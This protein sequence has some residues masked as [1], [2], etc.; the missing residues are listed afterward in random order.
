MSIYKSLLTFLTLF[1]TVIL[2]VQSQTLP[3]SLAE[4]KS[5]YDVNC[6]NCHGDAGQGAKKAGFEISIIAERGGYNLPT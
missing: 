5:L 1:A 6:A 4:G 3:E 2:P